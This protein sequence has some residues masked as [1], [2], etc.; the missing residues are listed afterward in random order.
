M[1]LFIQKATGHRNWLSHLTEQTK[2]FIKDEISFADDKLR[3]LFRLTLLYDIGIE[4]TDTSL[5]TIIQRINQW[6]K[7]NEL[8]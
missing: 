3:M 8:V 6:Y 1:D 2:R 5:D 4:L 7:L